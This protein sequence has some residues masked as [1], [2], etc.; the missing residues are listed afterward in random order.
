MGIKLKF[1]DNGEVVRAQPAYDS[2]G[3]PPAGDCCGIRC[4]RVQ[5][6][7]EL[8]ETESG[9]SKIICGEVGVSPFEIMRRDRKC[10]LNKWYMDKH[11]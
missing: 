2:H 7:E 9:F 1:N 6:F 10:P 11:P 3:K 5:V 4:D 8:Q